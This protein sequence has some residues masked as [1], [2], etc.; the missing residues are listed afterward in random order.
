MSLRD[1]AVF[2]SSERI[3][4]RVPDERDIDLVIDASTDTLIPLVT[5]V[6][7]NCS[8]REAQDFITRQQGRPAQGQG[9]SLTIVDRSSG[10]P[11]GNLFISCRS[12]DLGALELGYWVGP[13]HRG[14]GHAAEALSAVRDWAVGEFG[15]DRLTLYIDP[16]NVPSLRTADRAGFRMETTYDRWER[17]GD[18]FRPM[19]VWAYGPGRPQ[20]THIGHLEYRMWLGDYR[21]DPRWFDHHLHADFVEHG[22]S[23]VRWTRERIVA[24]PIDDEIVV[25]LP[26]AQQELRQLAS[27]TWMLT[28]VAH[29]SDRSYRRVS[30]WQELG[31][32]WRLRF[33]QGTPIPDPRDVP[34]HR[35]MPDRFEP[36]R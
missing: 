11:V 35:A 20:P 10:L 18:D 1:I 25:R 33:H 21:G 17:V 36:L 5:T 14:R 31:E 26:L 4:L 15:V 13:S 12:L 23:G 2:P 34:L 3:E 19:T 8:A 27:D 32:G 24:T 22:C 16:E 9:W 7:P 28:Y 6:A 30:I 29:Q